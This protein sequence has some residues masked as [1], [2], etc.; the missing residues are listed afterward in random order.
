MKRHY[1]DLGSASDWSGRVG[2]LLQPKV[3]LNLGGDTSSVWHGPISIYLT[4]IPRARMGSE[5]IAH[6]AEGQLVGKK[7]RE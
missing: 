2:N 3:L 5:S 4:I 1:P 6:E 7:Y